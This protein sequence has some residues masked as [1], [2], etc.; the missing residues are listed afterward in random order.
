[1]VVFADQ[2]HAAR[3]VRKTDATSITCRA[4]VLSSRV[5]SIGSRP[6]PSGKNGTNAVPD[7]V[8]SASSAESVEGLS[9]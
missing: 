6:P 1:M 7:R 9:V 4:A 8:H 5:V 2:I 3:F